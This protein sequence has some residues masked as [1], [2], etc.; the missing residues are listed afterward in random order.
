MDAISAYLTD[1]LFELEEAGVDYL[2]FNPR[3]GG[4][5]FY[6]DTLFTSRG[7][8]EQHPQRVKQFVEASLAGWRYALEHPE[9]IVD[10]ILSDYSTRHTREHLLFEAA[11]TQ[12]LIQPNIVEIGYVN[13]GRWRYIASVYADLGMM[14]PLSSL[15]GFLYERSPGPSLK[16]LFTG[17]GITAL[18]ALFVLG[19]AL[20]FYRLHAIVS[21]Q[22]E[23]LQR[24]LDDIRVL[25]GIIPVCSY[26]HKVRD[27]TGAWREMQ[28]YIQDH[29]EAQFSHG[30][31]AGC[32]IHVMP[33]EDAMKDERESG[34]GNAS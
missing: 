34:E 16:W 23:T 2:V 22:A 3:A 27:D 6:G 12:R 5:D 31:C 24:A 17:W 30:I 29:S 4:I 13:P 20:W 18:V 15:D 9:E 11:A 28:R 10:L 21:R 25:R 32:L 33:A 8:L 14:Q 26:C 7:Y 19:I 1:E